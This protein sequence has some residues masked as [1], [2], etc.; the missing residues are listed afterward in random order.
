M[1]SALRHRRVHGV[2]SILNNGDA[3]LLLNCDRARCAVTVPAGK[4]HADHALNTGH[5]NYSLPLT[6]IAPFLVRLITS[7]GDDERSR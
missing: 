6:E 1:L 2:I 4:H 5:P 7:L 3:A